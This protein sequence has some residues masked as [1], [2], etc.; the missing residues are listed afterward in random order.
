M[1]LNTVCY[2]A[3]LLGEA[4][5]LAV[6]SRVGT[7]PGTLRIDAL[8]RMNAITDVPVKLLELV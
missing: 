3:D 4:C 5:C 6:L 2:K 7:V 8:F 1:P